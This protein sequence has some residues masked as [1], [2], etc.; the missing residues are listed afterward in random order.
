MVVTR[1]R[2]LGMLGALLLLAAGIVAFGLRGRASVD[3]GAAGAPDDASDAAPPGLLAAPRRAAAKPVVP[4]PVPGEAGGAGE[5]TSIL[6]APALDIPFGSVV[7]D[8]ALPEERVPLD[9]MVV[10]RD[11]RPVPQ[12]KIVAVWGEWRTGAVAADDAGHA[13]LQV[14]RGTRAL[15]IVGAASGDARQFLFVHYHPLLGREASTR[16]VVR[17]GST[18]E[19]RLVTTDGT[20]IAGAQVRAV[21]QAYG[22]S[23]T[24]TDGDGKFHLDVLEGERVDVRFDG[25]VLGGATTS[26]ALG[27][28]Y[29]AGGRGRIRFPGD[30]SRPDDPEAPAPKASLRASEHGVLPGRSDLVLVAKPVPMDASLEVVVR[31][32]DGR[33]QAGASLRAMPAGRAEA[34]SAVTAAD[35]RAVLSRL[36][37]WPM[38][39]LVDAASDPADP[40]LFLAAILE[41]LRPGG[42][43]V[44]VVL[45]ETARLRG[46]VLDA[47]G[48]PV[49]GAWC[50]AAVGHEYTACFP[51]DAEGRFEVPS[52]A[53]RGTH[54]QISARYPMNEPT[55]R[56]VAQ[57]V[58]VGGSDVT[59]RLEGIRRPSERRPARGDAGK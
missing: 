13:T 36:P 34:V 46:R 9:V 4:T 49:A 25:L 41:D 58:V 15:E 17:T 7:D 51:S 29:Q 26:A 16:V 2:R 43:P 24:G 53:P 42:A 5:G 30:E 54:L 44:E 32:A 45:V 59:I 19:G 57:D 14:P 35:G 22:F 56:G 48:H 39:I 38:R 55:S 12:A 20:P 31:D 33:P 11:G 27:T 40:R 1:A 8:P 52:N 6:P 18:I 23:P 47:V 3:P 21:P 10:D 37:R 28:G 50:G